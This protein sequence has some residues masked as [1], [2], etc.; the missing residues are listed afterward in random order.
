VDS[1]ALHWAR[2]N[3]L[4]SVELTGRLVGDAIDEALLEDADGL[5]GPS[6]LHGIDS[7]PFDFTRRRATVLLRADDPRAVL[8]ERGILVTKGAVEDVLNV[9]SRMRTGGSEITLDATE[10]ARLLELGDRWAADGVRLLAVATAEREVTGRSLVPADERDLTLVGF[11]GFRDRLDPAAAAAVRALRLRGVGLVMITG[12]HPLVARRICRDAGLHVSRI[13][14]GRDLAALD[15][16]E[17]ARLAA[18]GTVFARVG[19][20]QK[21][22]I[23]RA[24]QGAG[25][26][27][28]YLGDGVNDAPALRAADVGISITGAA[29]LARESADVILV[30]KDLGVLEQAIVAGRRTFANTVKYIKI[31]LASNVGNVVSMLA[32]SVMLPFLP[33]LPLQVLIQNMCFDLSQLA[34]VYDRVDESEICRPR[35]FDRRDLARFVACVGPVGVLFDLASFGLFWWVLDA[36]GGPVGQALFHTG[37]FAE[38]LI[39]QGLALLLLRSRGRGAPR[40]AW[41][42]PAAAAALA[43]SGLLLPFSSLAGILDLR[44]LPLAALPLLAAVMAGYITATIAVRLLY[45][46]LFGRWL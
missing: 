18:S 37:W 7:I 3:A 6:G 41:P 45:Q 35:T 27:V 36:H 13:V 19:P 42:I 10:R 16:A 5:D 39:A 38:N 26:T 25:R 29:D 46:R 9:C 32:A 1:G 24:L 44:P 34:L 14:V 33:M 21:A 15:D 11:V 31:A 22:R 23:V 8:R 20:P 2:V 43:L 17:V 30:R 40:P 12:D 4:W 28:G